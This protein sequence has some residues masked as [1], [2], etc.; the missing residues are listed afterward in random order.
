MSFSDLRA[1]EIIKTLRRLNERCANRFPEASLTKLSNELL[2]TS[3]GINKRLKRLS[4]PYYAIRLLWVL[5]AIGVTLLG[6]TLFQYFIQEVTFDPANAA[7]DGLVIAF[8]DREGFALFQGLEAV[9]NVFILVGAGVFFVARAELI[10]KRRS[11]L[12]DL[13]VLRSFAHIID[14][15]QLTKDPPS[16]LGPDPKEEAPDM[17]HFQLM[18]YL[19]YCAEMLALIAKLSALYAQKSDDGIVMQAV[20]EIENLTTNLSRKIWQKIQIVSE[21]KPV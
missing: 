10:M 18:R 11:M 20:N 9:L 3:K 4:R 19:D 16:I 17:T 14:M 13:H 1:E 2:E 15:H 5:V 6:Y 12:R 21:M 7:G 8:K